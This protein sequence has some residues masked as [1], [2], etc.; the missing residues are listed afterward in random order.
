MNDQRV[1]VD[2]RHIEILLSTGERLDGEIFLQLYGQHLA[3]PQ[4]IDEALNGSESFLPLRR[5][6]KVQLVNL[7]QVMA[8]YAAAAEEFD[9]LLT[10]GDEHRVRVT[11]GAG[12][13]FEARIFVNLPHGHNRVKDYLNQPARFLSFLV[14]DQVVYLA[15][16]RILVVED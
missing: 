16:Q 3:G 15:R 10:L 4:R 2:S 6:G 13:P 11:P 9:P 8:V 12:D 1:N 14:G 5:A 7:D